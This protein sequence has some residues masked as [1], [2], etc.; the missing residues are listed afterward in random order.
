MGDPELWTLN[1]ERK[2][3]STLG[4]GVCAFI[5]ILPQRNSSFDQ[6]EKNILESDPLTIWALA[7]GI[8]TCSSES[9]TNFLDKSP[10]LSFVGQNGVGRIGRF[11]V[12]VLATENVFNL[13]SKAESE[14]RTRLNS[15]YGTL[16]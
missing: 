14:K 3:I 10:R 15:Y 6:M 2:C 16:I 9:G 4:G 11:L 1:K 5:A 8:M 7:L 13:K 12:S